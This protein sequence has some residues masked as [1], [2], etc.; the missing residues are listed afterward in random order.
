MEPTFEDAVKPPKLS[1]FLPMGTNVLFEASGKGT[2]TV[3]QLSELDDND[4]NRVKVR[5]H[6]RAE[7][8]TNFPNPMPQHLEHEED[9]S[10]CCASLKEVCA[11]H[12]CWLIDSSSNGGCGFHFLTSGSHLSNN[13]ALPRSC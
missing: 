1:V 2:E 9:H 4:A 13:E 6:T 10:E 7:D 3:G 11:S 12:E 8:D 5:I